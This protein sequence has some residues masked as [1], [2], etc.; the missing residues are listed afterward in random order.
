MLF[1]LLYLTDDSRDHVDL[2][3]QSNFLSLFRVI[4]N[5]P[6]INSIG[7]KQK[8]VLRVLRTIDSLLANMAKYGCEY[9]KSFFYNL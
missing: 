7:C 4:I 6:L 1:S 3:I 5:V 9:T 2:L 8:S